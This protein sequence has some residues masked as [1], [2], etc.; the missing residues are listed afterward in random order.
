MFR[1]LCFLLA[2]PAGDQ[3][4]GS[5]A[6]LIDPVDMTEETRRMGYPSAVDALRALPEGRQALV[7]GEDEGLVGVREDERLVR[8]REDERLV[9]MRGW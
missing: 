9:R 5:H 3:F 6:V 2:A 7:I 1:L 4:K 8:M